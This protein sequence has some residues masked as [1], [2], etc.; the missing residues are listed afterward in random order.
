MKK[1]ILCAD[2]KRFGTKTF[3][4][5]DAEDV[6]KLVEEYKEDYNDIQVIDVP[7]DIRPMY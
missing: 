1:L 6:D 2:H 5:C 7:D 4:L 3:G